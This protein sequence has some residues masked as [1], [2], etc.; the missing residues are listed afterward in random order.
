MQ[1]KKV[2]RALYKTIYKIFEQPSR[3]CAGLS[4]SFLFHS[5]CS[6]CLTSPRGEK[7]PDTAEVDV[8][9]QLIVAN[10]SQP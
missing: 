2:G 7:A 8:T 6:H 1:K 3:I 9:F 5:P 10:E 4:G